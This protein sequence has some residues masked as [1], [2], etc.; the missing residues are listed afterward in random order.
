METFSAKVTSNLK[1]SKDNTISIEA[2]KITSS[3]MNSNDTTNFNA[4]STYEP[5][6]LDNMDMDLL[7]DNLTTLLYLFNSL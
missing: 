2:Q 4:S 6:L 5:S 7:T 3:N 1:I